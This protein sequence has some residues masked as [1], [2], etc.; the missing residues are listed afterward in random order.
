MEK[1]SNLKREFITETFSYTDSDFYDYIRFIDELMYQMH[2]DRAVNLS[3]PGE[4]DVIVY[5]A[6]DYEK[7]K[8]PGREYSVLGKVNTNKKLIGKIASYFNI[9][10]YNHL[11]NFINKFKESL[12][13]ENGEFFKSG[14]RFSVWDIIR[15]T[16]EMG[17]KNE[18]FVKDFILK[19]WG[20]DS[21][22]VREA[23]SSYKDM[24]LGIDITFNIDGQEKTCQV[25]PL[26]DV[27]FKERGVVVIKSSGVIKNYKTDFI[28]FVN[29]EKSYGDKC[30][31]FKNEGVV[32][33]SKSKTIT[34]PYEKL[35]NKK[36]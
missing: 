23:T 16:E 24:I 10:D 30:L 17:E 12:F 25:K 7:N 28:A 36:Y 31:F 8:I 20:S 34:I 29:I 19:T 32:Y 1:F 9:K 26:K 3:Q 5:K 18:E 35:V 4:K 15:S 22:P 21:N 6:F 13:T 33:D 11:K 27:S 2:S 14:S